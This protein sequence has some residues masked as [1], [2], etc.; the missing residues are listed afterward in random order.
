MVSKPAVKSTAAKPA[1]KP[2]SKPAAKPAAPVDP[3]LQKY[4]KLRKSDPV[5][6]KELGTKI[7]LKKY[8]APTEG[9]IA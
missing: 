3:E 5:K 4:E 6:A 7:W 2:V 1:T 9:D 8:G